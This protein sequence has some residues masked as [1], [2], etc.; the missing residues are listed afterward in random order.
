MLCTVSGILV[1]PNGQRL[2][3]G[4]VTF[5]LSDPRPRPVGVQKTIVPQSVRVTSN[6]EGEVTATLLPGR[7]TVKIAKFN[8]FAIQV[9]DAPSA[10]LSQIQ[11]VPPTNDP[12]G[13]NL[14]IEAT[15][16]ARDEVASMV[17]VVE[18][19]R[20]QIFGVEFAT[21]AQG[22]LAE[23]AL[24]PGAQI[25]WTDITGRPTLG[26]AAAAAVGDFATAAQGALAGTA[27]QPG[28]KIPWSDVNN[29][30]A[31]VSGT[32]AAFTTEQAT[33]LAGVATDA[34]VG[35]TWGVNITNQPALG[36]A[37]ALNVGTAVGT[38]AAGNDTRFTDA[39]EWSASTIAQAEAEAG[40]A[41]TRRA[42]TAQRVRQAVTAWWGTITASALRAK[43]ELGT[44]ATANVGDFATSGHSHGNA[45][46]SAAGFLSAAD[47]TK[48]DGVAANATANATDASLRDRGT[49]TGAQAIST[50][51]GLQAALDGK[52]GLSV[53][54][55]I[56]TG[57]TYTLALG[58]AG[59]IVTAV[60]ADPVTI[61]IPTNASVAF[62]VGTVVNVLASGAGA[63]TVE[64]AFGVTINGAWGAV[65]IAAQWQGVALVQVAANTWIA[66][67]ALSE[68]AFDFYVDSVAG[69]DANDGT[70]PEAAFQTIAAA[71][72]AALSYGNGVR[73][74]LAR[75]SEWHEQLNLS[76][77][78]GVMV[79]DYG[80][81]EQPMPRLDAR[82][83][84]TGW[85]KTAG[86][87]NVYQFD[88]TPTLGNKVAPSLW[89]DG[90]RLKRVA[91]IDAVDAEAG[92]FFA[93][94][95]YT[96]NV[97]APVYVHPTGSGDPATNNRV[98]LQATRRHC[99]W[100][101]DNST[102]RDVR[103]VAN[104][105]N[106]GIIV[107]ERF[108]MVER[109]ILE[110]GAVHHL[111]TGSG[112]VR[113]SWC[114][115]ND[116][117]RDVFN[118]AGMSAFIGYNT[119]NSV[120]PMRWERSG[121][122]SGAESDATGAGGAFFAHSQLGQT[123][124]GTVEVVD[125]E[126][127][128]LEGLVSGAAEAQ[129]LMVDGALAYNCGRLL[130][131]SVVTATL[132][133]GADVVR[134]EWVMDRDM[135]ETNF[136]GFWRPQTADARDVRI[137][138]C[139]AVRLGGATNRNAG[140]PF[141]HSVP[142]SAGSLLIER[143][144]V[145]QEMAIGSMQNHSAFS[146][147]AS[148]GT[149][150]VDVRNC[151]TQNFGGRWGGNA[152]GIHLHVAAGVTYTGSGNVFM[153]QD[154]ATE[155]GEVLFNGTT[156]MNASA[157]LAAVQPGN[158]VGSVSVSESQITGSLANRDYTF[159]GQAVAQGSVPNM[160]RKY[161]GVSLSDRKAALVAWLESA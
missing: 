107:L 45:T 71:Q 40:T 55:N 113:D 97:A 82:D 17:T 73:L 29:I 158:E 109:C 28:A 44:A 7:Y 156:Y 66:S 149:L 95:T 65:E 132:P 115:K 9:P 94:A 64:G 42:W 86:R 103:G 98:Y 3:N 63:V 62:P 22:E 148:T 52:A 108:A 131:N 140:Q 37:A 104:Q 23:T 100:L 90:V 47:K 69:D 135:T 76:S 16:L 58:D 67:G 38:V 152:R 101:G 159:T 60:N 48:L 123:S 150:Q 15:Q 118:A 79:D 99:I 24:Q 19:I 35:A 147:N 20:D 130:S 106:D 14:A 154:G 12:S 85:T 128:D 27:L 56:Q 124:F 133:G 111:F 134:S 136:R 121:Y 96:E 32:T 31:A 119:A 161:P 160:V 83:E 77:L 145:L 157:Y 137:R 21:V 87:T 50:V 1:T 39:R 129:A 92:T 138:D 116:R 26:T 151:L 13:F 139:V 80:D 34:T 57:T 153:G 110:D 5:E 11:D 43:A 93:S 25:P 10:I 41:T 125:C 105:H 59:G 117:T 54:V 75:G 51:I 53:P 30:P 18:E 144:A 81:A 127:Y 88:W 46:T 6:A 155:R 70:S 8:S 68:L 146:F 49:H 142:G 72:A 114:W 33:K 112:L 61:T 2:V 78:T 74:G 126:G 84:V 91:S 122:V 143:V 141:A 36:E 89:E 102:V 120:D 4:S